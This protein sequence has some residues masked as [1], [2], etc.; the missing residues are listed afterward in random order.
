M[1]MIQT[2]K[3]N[4]SL[5]IEY[6]Y[7][8]LISEALWKEQY[9]YYAYG[10]GPLTIDE[11]SDDLRT[12]DGFH[13]FVD[14]FGW[15]DV[16]DGKIEPLP[17]QDRGFDSEAVGDFLERFLSRDS[18]DPSTDLNNFRIWLV[19]EPHENALSVSS[20]I[21]DMYGAHPA[22]HRL[23]V[24]MPEVMTALK[25]LLANMEAQHGDYEDGIATELPL[26]VNSE[27]VKAIMIVYEVAAR[28]LKVDDLRRQQRVLFP[29]N[30]PTMPDILDANSALRQ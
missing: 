24:L 20:G 7:R 14:A 5:S 30:E 8:D 28:L 18:C 27:I 21:K 17:A 16:T 15:P 4:L 1:D 25:A 22:L 6:D 26:G 13:E 19:S 9:I 23:Y 10:E 2:G 12:S 11:L 3:H 29:G